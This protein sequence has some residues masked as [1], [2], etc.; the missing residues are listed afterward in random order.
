MGVIVIKQ[1]LGSIN[2]KG[3]KQLVTKLLQLRIFVKKKK[4]NFN[5]KR[6]FFFLTVSISAELIKQI[7]N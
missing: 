7:V 5:E 4:I 2:D 3:Q 1:L 6:I